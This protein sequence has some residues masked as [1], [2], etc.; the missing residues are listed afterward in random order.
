ME[1]FTVLVDELAGRGVAAGQMFGKPT[2]KNADGKALACLFG[3]S[4]AFRLVAGTAEH[5]RA[6]GLAGA[7]LFDPSGKG[8]AMKDWVLVPGAHRAHFVEFATAALDRLA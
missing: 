2:L 3:G 1:A 6:L 8:R 5:A 4:V 7:E